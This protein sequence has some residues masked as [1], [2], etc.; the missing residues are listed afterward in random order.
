[1]AE[2]DSPPAGACQG[3]TKT[4]SPCS[5][6]SAPGRG[7][8]LHH[9]PD[10]EVERRQRYSE[11]GRAGALAKHSKERKR[12]VEVAVS[13]GSVDAIRACLERALG[14]LEAS[15]VGPVE[16]AN[17]TARLAAVALRILEVRDLVVE[18]DELRGLVE[19]HIRRAA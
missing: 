4:G 8:C 14:L 7:W 19:K 9:D 11:L 10:R 13:L 6:A 18:V 3:R 16:R 1:M 12:A 15:D 5:Y 17:C 2:H